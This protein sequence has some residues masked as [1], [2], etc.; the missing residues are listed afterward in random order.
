MTDIEM[1]IG[2]TFNNP[3]LLDMAMTHSSYYNENRRTSPGSNERLEFLGDAVLG[4]LTGEY[5]YRAHPTMPEGELTKLRSKL[6]CEPSL[7]AVANDLALG[8]LLQLGKGEQSCGG[9]TRP[10]V[11]A[12]AVEALLAAVYL[13]GGLPAAQ[14][15]YD[16]SIRPIVTEKAAFTDYKTQ[17]QEIVQRQPNRVITYSLDREDGPDHAKIFTAGVHID[18]IRRG[19]G[20]GGSRKEAEQHAAAAAMGDSSW[21]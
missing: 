1:R 18:C 13:D 6:V 3:A 9:R 19:T 4:L 8:D 21:Y 20:Q 10:S 16:R 2:Y 12:D 15:F 7:C 17:L 14:A 11:L 5:L